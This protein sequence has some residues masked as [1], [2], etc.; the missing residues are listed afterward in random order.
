LNDGPRDVVE[1]GRDRVTTDEDEDGGGANRDGRGRG[2]HGRRMQRIEDIALSQVGHV[3]S[4]TIFDVTPQRCVRQA[5]SVVLNDG[6]VN[7][8][9]AHKIHLIST[10]K[11]IN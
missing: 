11:I 8:L 3:R 5:R 9:Q 6:I 10:R 2:Q 7:G 1:S 4:H